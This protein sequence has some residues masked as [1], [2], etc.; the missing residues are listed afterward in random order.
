MSNQAGRAETD[1]PRDL[2]G[3]L[4]LAPS[5]RLLAGSL[6]V[7]C[8]IVVAVLGVLF[9]HQ[10]SVDPFDQVVDAPLIHWFGTRQDLGLWLLSP[11]APAPAAVLSVVIVLGC[12]IAGRLNGA[13]LAAVAVPTAEGLNEGLLKPLV[14]R[15]YLGNLVYPSGHTTAIFTIAATVTV[16]CLVSPRQFTPT[17]SVPRH[18]AARPGRPWVL[19]AVIPVIACLIGLIVASALIG[20]QWHYFTDTVAGAD[21]GIGTVSGLA[22]ILDSPAPSRWLAAGSQRLSRRWRAMTTIK[23]GD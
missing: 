21:V 8:A 11:G 16:L 6:L 9:T 13:V 5:A 15:T 4:L 10:T 1:S 18:S 7:C 2:P 19:R 3:R 12:L 20:L 22:L 17:H 23:I 14:H